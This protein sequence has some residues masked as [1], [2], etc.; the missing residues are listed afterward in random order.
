MLECTHGT[1]DF[2]LKCCTFVIFFSAHAS[3]MQTIHY[4]GVIQSHDRESIRQL[5]SH[6]FWAVSSSEAE[7]EQL[8]GAQSL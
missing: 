5:S 2:H 8:A 7:L 1:K 4:F 3:Q 6:S